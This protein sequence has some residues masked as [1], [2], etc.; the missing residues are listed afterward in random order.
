MEIVDRLFALVED[1]SVPESKFKFT[2]S[3]PKS[4]TKKN[5]EL[6][7]NIKYK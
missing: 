1:L 2:K 5:S 4:Y 6:N 3:G 7:F